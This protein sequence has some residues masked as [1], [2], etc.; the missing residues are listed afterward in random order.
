MF[1][2]KSI[3]KKL[4]ITNE[5]ESNR[6]EWVKSA[7]KE[8]P[9]GLRIL[10][11][12]A[13]EKQYKPFCDHLSY[14][15]QDFGQYDGKGD[16][17]GLQTGEWDQSNLDIVCD[18]AQIPEPD[19]SFDAVLCTE[20]F[21]HIP[22]PIEAIQEFS[23]LVK[24]G[25]HLIITAPFCSFTHF[26]PYHYY[27][28]YNT[29]FWEHYLP[30]YG[31]KITEMTPNGNFFEYAAQEVSRI[32]NASNQYVGKKP[33]IHE[34]VALYLVVKMLKRFSKLDKN[35]SSLVCYGYHVKAVKI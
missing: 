4:N 23:R 29:Y 15:S 28:G 22:H 1:S 20:V 33:Y 14:V 17:I 11:A 3:A 9:D 25:G 18:I 26:A 16:S 2:I 19:N 8:L 31:F 24:S 6:I 12:G 10:D 7:L 34:L 13:G 32:Y 5:N 21:E 30:K 35:S 27:S